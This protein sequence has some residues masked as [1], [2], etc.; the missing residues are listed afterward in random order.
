MQ[1]LRIDSR[2]FV[3]IPAGAQCERVN[4]AQ[5]LTTLETRDGD[6]Q[7]VLGSDAE[8]SDTTMYAPL[9]ACQAG[10]GAAAV[11]ARE[12]ATYSWSVEGA[13]IV[14]GAGTS[15][16]SL[17]FGDSGNVKLTCVITTAECS[18]ISS[19]VIAVRERIAIAQLLVPPTAN[20][21]EPLTIT[22]SYA[23]GSPASQLLT[24][25]ALETPIVIPASARSYTFTPKRAGTRAV[26]LRA[27]Y[28]AT[29]S[30]KPVKS[31]RRAM[32][33]SSATASEC[34]IVSAIR[35]MEVTG[36]TT[37]EPLISRPGS[38]IDAGETF[39]VEVLLEPGEEAQWSVENGSLMSTGAQ[40]GHALV[41][42]G[43]SGV[44]KVIVTLVRGTC[45]RV[46]STSLPI[47][48]AAQQCSVSPTATLTL[49]SRN[50]TSALIRATF[51]GAQPFQGTWPDGTKFFTHSSSIERT[52]EGPGTYGIT[53]FRDAT[54]I[55]VV[56][57]P[58]RVES[59]LP[60]ATLEV[61]GGACTKGRLVATLS[62][63]PPFRF[64]WGSGSS[65]P[66]VT[67][68]DTRIEKELGPGD[69]GQW[70]VTELQDAS[71]YAGSSN[72]VT[73]RP[74]PTVD[75][76]P[77]PFCQYTE[78]D[79]PA[80]LVTLPS[81]APPFS[82]TWSDGVVSSSNSTVLGRIFPKPAVPLQQY[83]IV[84]A[85]GMTGRDA[86]A[87]LCA[88]E[89]RNA[90]TTVSYRPRPKIDETKLPIY[91]C[92]GTPTTAT[93]AAPMPAAASIRWSL[94]DGEILSGQGTAT[95]TFRPI[96]GNRWGNITVETTY[97]DGACPSSDW[98][99][100][101]LL[102]AL[103]DRLTVKPSTI[104]RNQATKITF[105]T[106]SSVTARK[107]TVNP[108]ARLRDIGP[109][110]CSGFDC[111]ATYTDSVGPGTATIELQYSGQ[112]TGDTKSAF[113]T[114]TITE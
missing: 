87:T 24:G 71:C 37:T 79:A 84:S 70:S 32:G 61:A 33:R 21:E 36:C 97:P 105:M 42:A 69:A 94:P 18:T 47:E 31:R 41:R 101:G 16:V 22:W 52:F 11:P 27:S 57:A 64:R 82:V 26:E 109:I 95:M 9:F 100:I 89:I 80:I 48:P 85:T 51:A 62:G 25:D 34:A 114:L 54:C 23:A 75:V 72:A 6:V 96:V 73:I 81:G 4:S 14:A 68:S 2:E 113:T 56:S 20:G 43:A 44:V 53:G 99:Y 92:W 58:I 8:C 108:P 35:N 59:I 112:C 1:L 102:G 55:G 63:T 76:Q 74:A 28:F 19:A 3:D 111:S 5:P 30:A 107:L 65:S 86:A 88:A 93:L 98:H 66:V 12:G 50:C 10:T 110:S 90:T 106:D 17:A 39:E 15:R 78:L 83:T 67:T 46:G 103:D 49:V 104:R 45:T 40:R 91:A 77:G 7:R 29:M 60:T 38:F 13:A